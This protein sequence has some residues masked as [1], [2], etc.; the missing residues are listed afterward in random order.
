[1]EIHARSSPTPLYSN[2]TLAVFLPTMVWG[3]HA[4]LMGKFDAGRWLTL[5][6]DM[7]ATHT[8]LVPVQYQRLC[9]A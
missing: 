1:M 2:T 8:M 6:Q 4:R 7:R 3:G 9:A 5:A